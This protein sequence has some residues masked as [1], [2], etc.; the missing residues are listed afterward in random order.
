MDS[1]IT[2]S[3]AAGVMVDGTRTW[4]TV[5]RSDMTEALKVRAKR[6]RNPHYDGEP[7]WTAGQREYRPCQTTARLR[8]GVEFSQTVARSS[9]E[10]CNRIYDNAPRRTR[11]RA[12]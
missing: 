6:I 2:S 5:A 7:T 1:E 11:C 12:I 4:S 10:K 3:A 9:A 8:S